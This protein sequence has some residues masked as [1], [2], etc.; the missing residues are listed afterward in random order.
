MNKPSFKLR[1]PT[2]ADLRRQ[3][4]RSLLI[5]RQIA[6]TIAASMAPMSPSSSKRPIVQSEISSSDDEDGP[7]SDSVTS[8]NMFGSS[9]ESSEQSVTP[10]M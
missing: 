9:V 6:S 5:Q 10:N 7:V 2:N 4:Y 1:R 3:K 8:S